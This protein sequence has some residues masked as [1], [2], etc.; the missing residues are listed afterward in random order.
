MKEVVKV[1]RANKNIS[2]AYMGRNGYVIV[3]P[4]QDIDFYYMGQPLEDFRVGRDEYLIA[5]KYYDFKYASHFN[6]LIYEIRIKEV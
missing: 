1:L 2:S 3:L 4:R 6:T 5:D